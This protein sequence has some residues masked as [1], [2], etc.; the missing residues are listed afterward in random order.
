M[1]GDWVPRGIDTQTPSTARIYDYVLGGKDNF[2][3]DR[4]AAEKVFA[5]M[6]EVREIAQTNRVFLQ[7]AVRLC[8]EAG[9]TQ[10]IDVGTGI[11]TYPA[12]HDIA[13]EVAPEARVVYVDNDP[14]ALAHARALLAKVGGGDRV[15]VIEADMRDS[16]AIFD[17]AQLRGL[18]DWNQPVA[19]LLLLMLHF[20]TDEE[21]PARVVAEFRRQ[22]APGSHMAITHV[23]DDAV[24]QEDARR[25][26]AVYEGATSTVTCRSA[27][28]IREI[29]GDFTLVEPGLV[30]LEQW[31]P[32]M[33]PPAPA[34]EFKQSWI[35]AA[36]GRLDTS[37]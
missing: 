26:E 20:V 7:R 19:V 36:L 28:R 13:H 31:R 3:P 10:F 4:E 29:L 21:G 34:E 25:L 16:G 11:P 6:P 18:I 33:D 32:D 27:G 1:T 17:H 22:M 15:G 24:P 35:Y 12:V 5:T 30:F 8:A 9:I 23:S 2:A 14:I 37:Q